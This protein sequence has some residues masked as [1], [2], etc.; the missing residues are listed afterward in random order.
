MSVLNAERIYFI[1]IG[2][3]GM[4]ALAR[5]FLQQGKQVGGY[6]RTATAITHTLSSLGAEIHYQD[7]FNMV[8]E[9]FKDAS[10]TLVVY[11]PAIPASHQEL[12][13]F[14]VQDFTILKRSHVLGMIAN[15]GYCMAVAGTHG[16]TTTSAILAHLLKECGIKVTAFLG[17]ILENTNSNLVLE[18]NDVMVVEA[19][20]FDRSFLQLQPDVACITSMD[21]DHLDI[22]DSHE[23]LQATFKEFAQRI[24]KPQALYVRQGLPLDGI[25]FGLDSSATI[26]AQQICVENGGYTFDIHAGDEIIRSVRFALPGYHN[27]ANALAAF[28]MA[29]NVC[30]S[31]EQLA[32]ALSSF[33]GVHRRFSYRLKSPQVLIDDYAHH[34]SEIDAVYQAVS[35]F[36]PDKKNVAVFQPHLFSRTR[37][38]CD[39]FAKS[40]SQFDA[41]ILLDIYPAREEPIPNVS[42]AVLLDKISLKNKSL[43]SKPQLIHQSQLLT[44]EVVVM[45]GAG[46]IADEVRSV[47]QL[48]AAQK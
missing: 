44:S 39:A 2:G 25:T 18:G 5:Y 31:K 32:E 21:A 3:I 4:S 41:V 33:Q 43:V 48:I 13:A 37:D 30:D 40:L 35:T 23:N 24:K 11:T 12:N 36:Y 16:K 20:E 28:A 45:M 34:P 29:L 7:S 46:D 19:D 22:Y 8:P 9:V 17:G 26:S 6:D 10:K 27:I 1:G 15:Q 38:F 47:Q 42:S 14:Q